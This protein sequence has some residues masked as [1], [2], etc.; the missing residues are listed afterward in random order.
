MASAA[1]IDAR[2]EEI[3]VLEA[4]YG[5]DFVVISE[6]EWQISLPDSGAALDVQLPGGYPSTDAPSVMLRFDGAKSDADRLKE[7]LKALWQPGEGCIF[8]MVDYSKEFLQSLTASPSSPAVAAEA[9]AESEG[10]ESRLLPCLEIE[11]EAA[12]KVSKAAIAAGFVDCSG[13]VFSHS[14]RGVT[15]EIDYAGSKRQLTITVDG[16]DAEDLVDWATMQIAADADSFGKRLLSWVQAQRSAEPG[17]TDADGEE[18]EG[19]IEFLPTPESLGVNKDRQLHIYTWGKALRKAMPP[20]SEFN[21]NAGVL[22]GRG[23]GADLRTMN[24]LDEEVQK[25]VLSCGLFPRWIEMCCHK[26]EHSDCHTISINCTKGRHRSVAAAE[27]LR[28]VYYPKATMKHLT[29]Y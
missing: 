7:E 17:F 13:G 21:F 23:G 25:N 2:N 26:V 14:D 29:I 22:N 12:N 11:D 28:K 8:Q 19:G 27:I 10:M 20:D 18:Q 6:S 9:S 3:G 24:G 15:L 1:D 5:T 16:I 4:I